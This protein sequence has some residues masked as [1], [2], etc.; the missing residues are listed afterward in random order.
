MAPTVS[1]R[2]FVETTAGLVIGFSIGPR[3]VPGALARRTGPFTPNAW[4]RI[5]P[6]GIVTLTLDRSEMGQGSQTGLAILLAEELD[7][8]WS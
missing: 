3:A 1:R 5:D 7:A 4:I 8:D 6:D 2:Q